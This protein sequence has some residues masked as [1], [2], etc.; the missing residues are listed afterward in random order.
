MR[1][2]PA[3]RV[4]THGAW[5][6]AAGLRILPAIMALVLLVCIFPLTISGAGEDD[7][8]QAEQA[9]FSPEAASVFNKRCTACHTYGKG[10]KVGPD[11]KGVNDRRKRDWLL[12]FI[13]SS[14]TVI[15]SGDPTA[16][17]LFAQFK[18]QRMPDWTDLSDKQIG[19]ILQYLAVGGPDIKPAD[20]RSAEL[21]TAAE[22][23]RG[24]Q[25]FFG[26]ARLRY[27]G[28]A[29]STCHSLQGA[30]W[31]G[32]SLA[33]DLTHV[34]LRYQDQALTSFLKNPCFQWKTKDSDERYLTP[35][36]SFSLKA[37]LRQS[38]IQKRGT[39]QTTGQSESKDRLAAA[40]SGAKRGTEQ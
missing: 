30:G 33:P 34:Y 11:L 8:D 24:R 7:E 19:D 21:A 25:L 27:A 10:I 35:R 40:F 15:K 20:E 22:I 1:S 36:E 26:E 6:V 28:V 38:S 39:A 17:S 23:E 18:Q 14:S 31:R 32:G 13:H 5:A 29:C 12:K 4:P 16:T 3:S 2:K 37:F 9:K